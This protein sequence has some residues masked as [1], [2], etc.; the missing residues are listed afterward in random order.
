MTY[1]ISKISP[2]RGNQSDVAYLYNVCKFS[3]GGAVCL[4]PCKGAM[5]EK[6]DNVIHR[7]H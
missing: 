5:L 6:K 2:E 1:Y 4:W 7:Y 3:A